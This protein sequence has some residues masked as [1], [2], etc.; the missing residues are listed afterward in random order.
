MVVTNQPFTAKGPEIDAKKAG[1]IFGEGVNTLPEAISNTLYSP[2]HRCTVL[3]YE[4]VKAQGSEATFVRPSAM[5][6]REHLIRARLWAA[7]QGLWRREP[8]GED[9]VKGLQ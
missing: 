4:F 1:E 7:I 6:G 8:R 3:I 5:P 9:R 2:Q